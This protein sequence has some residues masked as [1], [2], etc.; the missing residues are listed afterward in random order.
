MTETRLL[1]LALRILG[2]STLIS[3]LQYIGQGSTYWI[4]SQDN[5]S[6]VSKTGWFL[7]GMMPILF[8]GVISYVLLRFPDQVAKKLTPHG[9]PI[10]LG[11]ATDFEKLFDL[12]LRVIGVV[13]LVWFIPANLVQIVLN[14]SAHPVTGVEYELRTGGWNL[15]LRT[16]LQLICG[17]YL[18]KGAPGL[19]RPT[20]K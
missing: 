7:A 5:Q 2:V 13:L 3:L 9:D 1:A 11:N 17:A 6:L 15:I 4:M 19:S 18:L 12:C 10:S 8:S 14:F 16:I 20:F